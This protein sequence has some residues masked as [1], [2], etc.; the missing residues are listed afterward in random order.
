MV[1]PVSFGY[2]EQT[3]GNN[4]FMSMTHTQDIQGRALFEFEEY[5]NLLEENGV[6]IAI[7][8]DTVNPNTPDSIFPNNWFTTHSGG[9]LVLYPMFAPNRRAER[10][11]VFLN[12]IKKSFSVKRLIDLT[13][14]EKDGEFLEG[15]GSMVL[16]RD[17]KI[18]YACRS[19]RT[20][21]K[22]LSAFCRELGY[23][24]FIFD[25]VGRSNMPIYHTNVLMS[26][27]SDFAVVCLETIKDK[28]QR[29]AIV[30]LLGDSGKDIIEISYD[31]LCRYAG[32]M[33]EMRSSQGE[34][35]L[36][37]SSAAKESLSPGQL[38]VLEARCKIIS[39]EVNLIE[40]NGGGSARCMLAELF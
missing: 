2:N 26:I 36:A 17:R 3:A 18:A 31:Q 25:A 1:R 32:N 35:L 5:K 6:K 20:S 9:E 10:K 7:A 14:F 40:I 21:E 27:G 23:T 39:P 12:E 34:R 19:P 33:L 8:T 11:E 28:A 24:S 30:K 13:G 29:K 4:E 37:M 22:V 38:E 15:T 16:D